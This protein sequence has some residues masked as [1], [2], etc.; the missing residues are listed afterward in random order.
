MP[1][2]TESLLRTYADSDGLALAGLVRKGEVSPGELVEA[3]V[4]T[5]EK[6][7]PELNAVVHKLYDIGRMAAVAVDR[8]APFAGVPYL[9]KELATSWKGTPNTNSSVYLKDVVADFDAE[10]VTRIKKAGFLLVGKSNAPENGWSIS[11]EPKLYGAT[12]NPWRADVTA[13]GS[14]GGSSAAVAARMVPVA[15][16]SDAAGSIRVPA[17]CCGVLGL[18]PSRG[19]VTMAPFGDVWHG[20]AYFLANTRTVRDTAAY[21]DAVAGA[22]P[23]D[24]YQPPVPEK[25][26]LELSRRSPRKLRVGFTVTPPHGRPIDPEVRRAVLDTARLLERLGH[27]VEEHDMS[28][29][30]GRIWRT[31]TNMSCVQTAAVF[32]WLEGA[33]GR[34]VT[35]NDVEPITWAIIERGRATSGI[36]HISDV[37]AVRQASRAI[38]TDLDGYDIYL[39]PTLTQL[40]RPV[41][42]YDMSMTDLDAYNDLWTD[43]VFMFPFDISGQPAMSIPL[44]M[45]ESGVPIGVQ[46]VGRYGDEATV[47]ALAV[48]LEQEMPWKD[49]RPKVSA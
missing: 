16:S 32:D 33:L 5:I 49:R 27:D 45:S 34:P 20:C 40:P 41:G 3:A 29:D 23:G 28:L 12:V 7:N 2:V 42:F 4:A 19:R 46:A 15:E 24:P 36:S 43:S 13:G 21:L 48:V 1:G 9:L 38:A 30:A 6:L 31:Y 10:V 25:S 11:T 35:R 47:L 22:L 14:S 18:K 8:E 37:E 26:W 17:S 39:T 44:A